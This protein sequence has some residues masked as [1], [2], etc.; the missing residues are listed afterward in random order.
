MNYK[1]EGG[2]QD[3][4]SARLWFE[5]AAAH[6]HALAQ[7]NLSVMLF[8]AEGGVQDID[9]ALHWLQAAALQGHALAQSNLAHMHANGLGVA[10]NDV[11]AH[12]W[13]TLAAVSGFEGAR[14][15]R[16]KLEPRMS[17]DQLADAYRR[18]SDWVKKPQARLP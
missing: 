11:E 13:W 16:A 6:G 8:K 5:R 17:R 15:L 4:E 10:Q 7:F 2:P 1:G 3:H 18:A 14:Q 9:L 12:K